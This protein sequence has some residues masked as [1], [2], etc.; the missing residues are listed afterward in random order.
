M[1]WMPQP[2]PK[3]QISIF[4]LQNVRYFLHFAYKV[5]LNFHA[6]LIEI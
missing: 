6:A 4:I 5:E 2:T 3:S 1:W